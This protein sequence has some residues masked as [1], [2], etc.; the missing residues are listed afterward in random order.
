MSELN[1]LIN[2]IFLSE[3]KKAVL[4]KP[5]SKE[6]EYKKITCTEIKNKNNV[7][8]GRYIKE[9]EEVITKL[10]TY[11]DVEKNYSTFQDLIGEYSKILPSSK[12]DQQN[13]LLTDNGERQYLLTNSISSGITANS[14]QKVTSIFDWVI[15]ILSTLGKVN[16]KPEE[17]EDEQYIAILVTPHDKSLDDFYMYFKP[18]DYKCY[19]IK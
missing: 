14:G 2:G 7:S 8:S 5:S 10:G 3:I 18:M 13:F 12:N 11:L 16:T 9:K 17:N 1:E 4:S 19:I 6:N 15:D